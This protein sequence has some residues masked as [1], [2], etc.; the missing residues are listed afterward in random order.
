MK[1]YKS[2]HVLYGDQVV[3]SLALA[4]SHRVAF[5][6]DEGWL[7][8]G[9]SI[10]PISL[11][12]QKD[13]FVPKSYEPFEG[14]FG[15][16]SDSLP[17]GW[18]RLLLDRVL[19]SKGIDPMK[20]SSL[21]RLAIVGEKGMGALTYK[22]KHDFEADVS[23]LEL[24]EIFLECSQILNSSGSFVGS[25][26]RSKAYSPS[27]DTIF[28]MGGSSGGARPKVFYQLDGEDWIVKF[29]SSFDPKEI[30][31][32]E[33]DYAKCAVKCGIEMPKFRLLPSAHCEGFF[34]VQ[35]FD[36]CLQV[37][38]QSD[39]RNP[40]ND[41]QKDASEVTGIHK[42]RVHMA[43]VSALLET[44]HRIPNLDYHTLMLLTLKL[45]EDY[46]EVEK[47]FRR[48]C[49]NVW[50]HNRDDHSKNFSFL[51]TGGSWRLSPAYDLTYS[52]SIGGEHAT[53]I[54][55]KGRD[56]GMGDLLAVAERAKIDA[57]KAMHIATEVREIV[58]DNLDKYLRG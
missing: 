48:M 12:L 24:D 37:V 13:V 8:T 44:S 34:G 29:P 28:Q 41:V 30:G 7:E 47:M 6:Y 11:P 53:T 55:G 18:G 15:I 36:R 26:S 23:P 54:N 2:L 9:F 42:Q 35:R 21:D 38:K 25:P 14:L 52:S 33:Y 49:F 22:P 51:Y 16:F 45:T 10:S 46:G 39:L 58:Q 32:M 5:A 1:R 17:D 31:R 57:D 43:S 50:S 4:S 3:G 27:L 19:A 40:S 20:I 56:I